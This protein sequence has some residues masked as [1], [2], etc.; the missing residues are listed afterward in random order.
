MQNTAAGSMERLQIDLIDL[1]AHQ[2]SDGHRY[3]VHM[4]CHT[5]KFTWAE[6]IK[7]KVRLF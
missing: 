3:V 1:S 2:T 4:K 5:S 7:T 6:A